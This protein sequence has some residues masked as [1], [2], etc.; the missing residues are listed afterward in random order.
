M[1]TRPPGASLQLNAHREQRRVLAGERGIVS[2]EQDVVGHPR[3][4]QG[5]HVAEPTAPLL[6]IGLEQERDLARPGVALLHPAGERVQLSLF[7]PL[8]L[9]TGSHGQLLGRRALARHPP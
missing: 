4:A 3:P 9:L 6:E 2:L 7:A 5:V 8:P 1:I